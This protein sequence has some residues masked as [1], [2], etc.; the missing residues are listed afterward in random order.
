MRWSN[1][2]A[3]VAAVLSVAAVLAFGSGAVMAGGTQADAVVK[4]AQAGLQSWLDALP[5][6]ELNLYGFASTDELGIAQLGDPIEI[7]TMTP[8]DL[9]AAS[10]SNADKL[11]PRALAQ[12]YVPIIVDGRY[13]ALLSVDRTGGAWE[14]VGLSAAQLARELEQVTQQLP[15]EASRDGLSGLEA[16]KLL[17]I[18]QARA[19]LLYVK[20]SQGEYLVPLQ[21]ARLALKVTQEEWLT[22]A[23]AV[24]RLQTA[25]E[26]ALANEAAP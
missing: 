16:P 23:S 15:A 17:R 9:K 6:D 20:A 25:V 11:S 13:R 7:V 26:S 24:P 8:D 10:D 18:F 21:S 14:V 12:W 5:V 4:A 19:D 2:F 1:I 22:P 3:I